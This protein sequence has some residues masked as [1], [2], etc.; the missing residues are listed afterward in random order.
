MKTQIKLKNNSKKLKKYKTYKRKYNKL[1]LNTLKGGAAAVALSALSALHVPPAAANDIPSIKDLIYDANIVNVIINYNNLVLK[2]RF[3]NKNVYIGVHKLNC[4]HIIYKDTYSD[5]DSF[6]YNVSKKECVGQ[7]PNLSINNSEYRKQF[8]SNSGIL[9]EDYNK[10]LNETLFNLIDIIN[11]NANMKFCVLTDMS[12]KTTTHCNKIHLSLLKPIEKGYGFYNEFGYIYKY[13]YL[14]QI[15]NII[16]YY[17]YDKYISESNEILNR[18]ILKLR[19]TTLL[20]FQSLVFSLNPKTNIPKNIIPETYHDILL[21]DFVINI[22]N[23]CKTKDEQFNFE[24]IIENKNIITNQLESYI[25]SMTI[26]PIF[27]QSREDTDF[28]GQF[29]LYNI[30]DQTIS[31]LINK[32]KD[33]HRAFV[34]IPMKKHNIK[35]S[36]ID[37]RDF[38]Y[39]IDISHIHI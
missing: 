30:Q 36:P 31:A 19:N 18:T 26:N 7:G 14:S 8:I 15:K 37:L 11:I 23:I 32:D 34:M 33:E 12:T 17:D 21:K 35:I 39:Q 13:N 38:K 4:I 10:Q 27:K 1:K 20:D 3:G 28:T 9:Q 5:L 24:E 22:M 25:D 29:K 2:C 16:K 6:F